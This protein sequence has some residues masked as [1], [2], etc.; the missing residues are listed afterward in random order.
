MWELIAEA[1]V[2]EQYDHSLNERLHANL[3][4]LPLFGMKNMMRAKR[5]S[6]IRHHCLGILIDY[7]YC[8]RYGLLEVIG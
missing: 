7:L 3:S 1:Q 8:K 6:F 5:H 4:F 2:S